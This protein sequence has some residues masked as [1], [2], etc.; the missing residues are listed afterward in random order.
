MP[1][2]FLVFN[3]KPFHSNGLLNLFTQN[4]I[5]DFYFKNII[6]SYKIITFAHAIIYLAL[7]L[8]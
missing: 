4:G 7:F 2:L 5:V 3:Q 1:F 6:I 8:R